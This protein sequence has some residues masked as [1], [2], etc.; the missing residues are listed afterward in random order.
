MLQEIKTPECRKREYLDD[1]VAMIIV[2]ANK[3]HDPN[4]TCKEPIQ[5]LINRN[6]ADYIYEFM[7]FHESFVRHDG[8]IID[9]NRGPGDYHIDNLAGKDYVVVGGGLGECHY[10]AYLSLLA[11]RFTRET[12]IHLP[13]FGIYKTSEKYE[14]AGDTSLV[15]EINDINRKEYKMYTQLVKDVSDSYEIRKDGK[16][17]EYFGSRRMKL[18][19]WSS[20]EKMSEY[21]AELKTELDQTRRIR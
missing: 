20:Q 19:L 4:E 5:R 6:F 10:G 17:T 13:S 11:S 16:I 18:M 7:A 15:S 12:T 14:G 3:R 8:N 9:N 21:F 2:H 1:A